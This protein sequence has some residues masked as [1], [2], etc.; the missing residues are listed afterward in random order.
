MEMIKPH[1]LIDLNRFM[2][3]V[4]EGEL[5]IEDVRISYSSFFGVQ[6]L[7]AHHIKRLVELTKENT[8]QAVHV[9][10]ITLGTD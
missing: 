2:A 8:T 10:A 3:M 6:I 7:Y 1:L 9:L 5:V 4:F